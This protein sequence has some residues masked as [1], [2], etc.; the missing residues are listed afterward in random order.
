MADA[1]LTDLPV[2]PTTTQ[3]TDLQ[4]I[5]RDN[6]SYQT[7]LSNVGVASPLLF[8]AEGEDTLTTT[9]DTW[10]TAAT[11]QTAANK[12]YSLMIDVFAHRQG[13]EDYMY[14]IYHTLV[15]DNAGNATVVDHLTTISRKTTEKKLSFKIEVAGN[16]LSLQVKGRNGETWDWKVR[17]FDLE[18]T[19]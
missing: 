14:A 4:Y 7:P 2:L 17:E 19:I 1:R 3:P 8:E 9:N 10:T 15:V 16:I 6:V 11:Y 18:L 12:R 5:V 13:F